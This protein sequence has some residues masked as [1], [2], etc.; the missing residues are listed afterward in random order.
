MYATAA[1]SIGAANFWDDLVQTG[2]AMGNVLLYRHMYFI[3]FKLFINDQ[4]MVE[5]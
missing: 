2:C 5:L 4:L 3:A 1:A